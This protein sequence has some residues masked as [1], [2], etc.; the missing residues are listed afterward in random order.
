MVQTKI[1]THIHIPPDR[2]STHGVVKRASVAAHVL[3]PQLVGNELGLVAR[4]DTVLAQEV[5][6]QE[7][8]LVEELSQSRLFAELRVGEYKCEAFF[9][10]CSARLRERGVRNYLD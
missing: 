1:G 9:A 7:R 6:G 4:L 2:A 10:H 8:P 5:L 3:F